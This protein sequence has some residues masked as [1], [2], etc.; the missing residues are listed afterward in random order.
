MKLIPC[1]F[2]LPLADNDGKPFRPEVLIEIKCSLDQEF[3]GW[4][5]IGCAEGDEGSWF[6]QKEKSLT[7]EVRVV[8][9]DIS[10]L[11]KAVIAIGRRLGQKVMHFYNGHLIEVCETQAKGKGVGKKS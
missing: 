2:D 10:R 1:Q 4:K 3:G 8:K 9:K 6:G 5:I 11:K 7:I